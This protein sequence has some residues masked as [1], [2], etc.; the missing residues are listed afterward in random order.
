MIVK[1]AVLQ[2]H[3]GEKIAREDKLFLIRRRPDFVCLPEY[4]FIRPDCTG[5]EEAAQAMED[6]VAVLQRLSVDLETTVIGGSMVLKNGKGYANTSLIFS[7]G[8]LAGSYQKVNLYGKE[9]RRGLVPGKEITAFTID[10]ARVGVLICAD[11][12]NPQ[13][14]KSLKKQR[15]DM[16]FVPTTSP[17]R[18]DDT[19]FEKQLRDNTIFVRGAQL[20][21]AYVIKTCGV[22]TLFGNRLQGRS[23]IFAPWGI[24]ARTAVE[25]ENRQRIL[26]ALLDLEEIREFKEK[27]V[28]SAGVPAGENNGSSVPSPSD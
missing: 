11:V 10:G 9:S 24:L 14:F 12:L 27:M 3:L 19:L 17:Y 18:P 20:A 16:V 6:N 21:N 22:G 7:R 28:F 15:A 1:V 5:M 26:L 13:S 23:G 25:D 2:Y 8:R 4:Y